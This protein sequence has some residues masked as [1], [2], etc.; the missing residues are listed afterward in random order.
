M[1]VFLK[2]GR[3]IEVYI[4]HKKDKWGNR[5][6]FVRILKVN[7]PNLLE[8]QLDKIFIGSQKLRVNLSRFSRNQPLYPQ[9][10]RVKHN[11]INHARHVVRPE[12]SYAKVVQ[13]GAGGVNATNHG[14]R[15]GQ[16]NPHREWPG[17]TINVK[18][19]DLSWLQG[20]YVGEVSKLQDILKIQENLNEEGILGLKARPMGGPG[21]PNII[22][23][24]TG[25]SGAF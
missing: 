23:E 12:V 17:I 9:S 24:R 13:N 4:P 6:G 20:S 16:E 5:F 11:A 3:A 8:L 18:K 1:D 14:N 21:S 15:R 10:Q 25:C 2:W 19:E 22:S 7:N